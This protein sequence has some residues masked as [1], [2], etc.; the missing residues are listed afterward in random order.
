LTGYLAI[1]LA[2][3][4][5]KMETKTKT[6]SVGGSESSCYGSASEYGPG[7]LQRKLRTF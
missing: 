4:K 3:E 6:M 2:L 5:Y 1:R 7:K